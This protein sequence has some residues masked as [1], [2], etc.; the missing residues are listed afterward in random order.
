MLYEVITNTASLHKWFNSLFDKIN[1]AARL[2]FDDL[3]QQLQLFERQLR[4]IE[5]RIARTI[6]E[7]ALLNDTCARLHRITSYNVCYTK[8]L[9]CTNNTPMPKS[10]M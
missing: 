4:V 7:S 3:A 6:K 1:F 2:A 9:R 5:D 10:L 8:L